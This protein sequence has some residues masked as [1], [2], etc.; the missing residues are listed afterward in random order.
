MGRLDL[1]G[2]KLEE[3]VL[4]TLQTEGGGLVGFEEGQRRPDLEGARGLV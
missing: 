4:R 2:Q 3:S 1:F